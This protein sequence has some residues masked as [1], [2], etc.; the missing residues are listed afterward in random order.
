MEDF[1]KQAADLIQKQAFDAAATLLEES[2]RAMPA[3]WRPIQDLPDEHIIACWDTVEFLCYVGH[4]EKTSSKKRVVWVAPSYTQGY[5][6]LANARMDLGQVREAFQAVDRG[7]QL[8]PD[9]PQLL[10]EKTFIFGKLKRPTDAFALYQRAASARPTWT[11]SP[12][13]GR[14]LRGLGVTMVDFG[15]VDEAEAYLKE[16]LTGEPNNIIIEAQHQACVESPR[17]S[18]AQ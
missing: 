10:N 9:H 6:L 14:T 12:V 7:L 5:Y 3:T 17:A 4:F 13:R 2:L 1:N 18:W 16:S 8:E 15:K 11:P